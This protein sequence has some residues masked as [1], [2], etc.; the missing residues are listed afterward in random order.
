MV[1]EEVLG[2]SIEVEMEDHLH[3]VLICQLVVDT[4]LLEITLTQVVSEE[5]VLVETSTSG[6][7]VDNH[8]LLTVE[9]QEDLHTLVDQ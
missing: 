2:T 5:M 9:E 8:T 1:E 4:V 7:V 3:S 6:V